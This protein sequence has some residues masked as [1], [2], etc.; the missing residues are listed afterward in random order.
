VKRIVS[1]LLLLALACTGAGQKVGTMTGAFVSCAKADLGQIIA[2]SG[3]P[4]LDDVAALIEGAAASLEADLTALVTIVGIDAVQCAIA[5]VAAV[6][7]PKPPTN[8]STTAQAA[9]MPPGLVRALAW[10]AQ[11][12]K[13]K[14]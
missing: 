14:S 4:L 10:S 13:V 7:A 3:R 2:T 1:I 6:M 5:A 8:A 11:Q 9:P 12:N